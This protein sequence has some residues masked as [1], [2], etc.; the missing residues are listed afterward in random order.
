MFCCG[1][2]S[3]SNLKNYVNNYM[4]MIFTPYDTT[5]LEK[6]PEIGNDWENISTSR[7]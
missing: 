3:Y 1:I 5:S 7:V 6:I 4:R 2:N